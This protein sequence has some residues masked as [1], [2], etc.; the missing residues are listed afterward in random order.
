VSYPYYE[1]IMGSR[2]TAPLKLNLGH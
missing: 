1:G 2:G